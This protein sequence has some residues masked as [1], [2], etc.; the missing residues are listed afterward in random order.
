M[1][2]PEDG[3]NDSGVQESKPE[4]SAG[5]V[6][7]DTAEAGKN[8][9]TPSAPGRIHVPGDSVPPSG[10]ES[11]PSPRTGAEANGNEIQRTFRGVPLFYDYHED[12]YRAVLTSYEAYMLEYEAL[13][14]GWQ[15]HY[16]NV[17]GSVDL[18]L[19]L[20]P[21]DDK[22][23][24][25]EITPEEREKLKQIGCIALF[26]CGFNPT[27]ELSPKLKKA[28]H[29]GMIDLI[30]V[31]FSRSSL[32][33]SINFFL[34]LGIK[35]K[36]A[37]QTDLTNGAAANINTFLDRD[38]KWLEISR[39]GF[40][41]ETYITR[42]DVEVNA[43]IGAFETGERTTGFLDSYPMN[44]EDRPGLAVSTMVTAAT[45]LTIYGQIL[46]IIR[47]AEKDTGKEKPELIAKLRAIHARFNAFVL[48]LNATKMAELCKDKANVLIITDVNKVNLPD[49]GSS[50]Q[51]DRCAEENPE[52]MTERIMDAIKALV[53][54]VGIADPELVK[55][56]G[57]EARMSRKG[58]EEES[59]REIIGSVN[60][61]GY[62]DFETLGEKEPRQWMW[63]DDP[64]NEID[65]PG[66][67]HKV[68]AINF[69][70]DKRRWMM[71]INLLQNLP[72]EVIA[73]GD[74]MTAARTIKSELSGGAENGQGTQ[75][76]IS[77]RQA[78]LEWLKKLAI[79]KVD[80]PTDMTE[81]HRPFMHKGALEILHK[82][83]PNIIRQGWE[84]VLAYLQK[85]HQWLED[86]RTRGHVITGMDWLRRFVEELREEEK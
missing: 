71:I 58:G 69:K 84:P 25:N 56:V 86:E 20:S 45:F 80:V 17:Q 1:G 15:D 51:K 73:N 43:L 29:E 85:E 33:S 12:D 35:P 24:T 11:P 30:L 55:K 78:C 59:L 62:M 9:E 75:D 3:L 83:Y 76:D 27:R 38:K 81:R 26:G 42:I 50:D 6:L 79:P 16:D 64:G 74:P 47:K 67:G 19:G 18:A 61:L 53:S 54:G 72:G 2:S 10:E 28:L 23:G 13:A 37:Y 5:P 77:S 36:A 70:L 68:Q 40:N 52:A 66:H 31:D 14:S 32:R 63:W 22:N 21:R 4:Q 39:E 57:N 46:N 65:G 44:E 41:L 82:V 7:G 60:S 34:G 8:V 48:R 49:T